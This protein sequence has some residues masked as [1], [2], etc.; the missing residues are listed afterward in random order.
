[1][2]K[3][4]TN[5]IA[6]LAMSVICFSIPHKILA[7]AK[8]STNYQ[9]NYTVAPTGITHVK[10]FI[11][12]KNNLS[13]V[14]ATDFSL[15]VNNTK[16][17]NV[18][19]VDENVVIPA[20]VTKTRNQTSISFSFTNKIVGKDKNHF[21]SVE[22]DT[23]DVAT[24]F[25]NTW[26]I[27][28]PKL[29]QD[30]N[31]TD[32]NIILTVPPDFPKPAYIDP[33]PSVV[34]NNVYYFSGSQLANKPIGA[35]FGLSQFFKANLDYHLVND[36]DNSVEQSIALPPDTNYQS[37]FIENID[38]KP[39]RFET[40]EDGNLLAFYKLNAHTKLNI[41][42]AESIKVNFRPSPEKD[43]P[44][45]KYL[46]T[47]QIWDFESNI[48]TIP[49]V[50][51][52][53]TPKA[54]YD[55]VS[56]KLNYDYQKVNQNQ[57]QHYSASES[58]K[59]S[60]SAICTD[61]TNVFVAL[62]RK[63]G[64]PAREIEGYAF[65]ENSD[66]KPLSLT[67]DV[68]HAWPEYY[69]QDKHTWIQVDPTWANTTHG[70]DYFNKL[71]LNHITF[72]IHG[73]DPFS[74]VSAGGYKVGSSKT[75]DVDIQPLNEISF[76]D[77]TIEIKSVDQNNDKIEITFKN[78]SGIGYHNDLS[79]ENTKYFTSYTAPIVIAPFT[80]KKIEMD[81]INR[82]YLKPVGIKAI[83]YLNGQRLERNLT[84]Q[85]LIPTFALLSGAVVILGSVAL[86]ARRIHFRR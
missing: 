1:M 19:V 72:V 68:L 63:T 77:P 80:E 2:K 58:L 25:G 44:V 14:Y 45:Q 35:V 18:R 65:S 9:I 74:P 29:E 38:P 5:L 24:K 60:S 73:I 32:Q 71:D 20:D 76:P 15:S 37:V 30:E 83:I 51:N 4:F 21:F 6:I 54:I 41:S 59:N 16:I 53:T 81:L 28:I 13:V 22:Y 26:Q 42:V 52:L 62:A 70:V 31:L 78:V 3:L 8:F 17:N 36:L 47:N 10:F 86:T 55:Y 66:L 67:Q 34:I 56:D 23:E 33:N 48:F 82:P 46:A 49:E 12:Q 43:V 27:N 50:Q 75:K 84:I 64:I 40:D 57:S 11:N 85:P 61:F 39:I 69:D 7:L 79:V